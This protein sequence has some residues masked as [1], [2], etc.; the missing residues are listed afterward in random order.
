MLVGWFGIQLLLE[1][2]PLPLSLDRSTRI[3]PEVVSPS[4]L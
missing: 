2:P 3:F 4:S 1:P